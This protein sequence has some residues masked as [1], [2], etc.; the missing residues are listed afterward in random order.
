M[1]I[2]Y[3]CKYIKLMYLID[4]LIIYWKNIYNL[5]VKVKWT[6]FFCFDKI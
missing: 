5:T 6:S 2:F 3:L 1:D 4:L